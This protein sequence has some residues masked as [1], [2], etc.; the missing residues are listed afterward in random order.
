[1]HGSGTAV[2][3]AAQRASAQELLTPLNAASA[4]AVL[5]AGGT[6]WS[7]L[8]PVSVKLA[9]VG[10]VLAVTLAIHVLHELGHVVAG[11]LVGL[12][13]RSVTVG[14]LTVQ[15]EPHGAGW[16][17]TCDVNRSWRRVAGCVEREVTPA[18]GM[19]TA[20]TVTALGGP[21]A[22]LAVGAFLLALPEP[23]RGLGYVSL[24][25]GVFNAVP[26]VVLGQVS[27]GMIVYRLWSRR[28][29]HEAW[30]ARFVE[31][32]GAGAAST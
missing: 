11:L 7:P 24:F 19:R 14:L 1:M 15:R 23:W 6:F 16:R 30:R 18:P 28:P 13:F 4:W 17:L 12:P 9:L 20:L 3:E 25:V 21:L 31:G 22:N 32:A 10:A 29:S 8:A 2:S 5:V 26:S 27:D